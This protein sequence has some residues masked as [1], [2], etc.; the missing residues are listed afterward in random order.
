MMG[1]LILLLTQ[2]VYWAM[3]PMVIVERPA[4]T[5]L[6]SFMANQVYLKVL[7]A[8]FVVLLGDI[9]GDIIHYLLGRF[10]GQSVMNRFGKFFGINN[11]QL[12]K[13]KEK[14]FKV[15]ESLWGTVTWSKIT[16]APSSVVMFTAGFLRV[17]FRQYL[18]VITVNNVFKVMFFVVLGYIFGESYGAISKYTIDSWIIFV[19]IF[20]M[21]IYLLY[22]SKK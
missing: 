21:I 9:L 7:L 17:N 3:L 2:Y 15:D 22:G 13:V 1:W 20:L 8:Y 5:I 18:L 6:A 10:G 16:H 19:P 14:Y 11:E 4:I 12:E